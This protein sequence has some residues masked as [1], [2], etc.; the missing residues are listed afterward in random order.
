MGAGNSVKRA[1]VGNNF[2]CDREAIGAFVTVGL[3][4]GIEEPVTIIVGVCDSKKHYKE[5]LRELSFRATADIVWT[6]IEAFDDPDI[7]LYLNSDGGA[8]EL[9]REAS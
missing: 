9:V 2:C 3:L 5:A 4:H 8:Y 1:C 6:P 7:W